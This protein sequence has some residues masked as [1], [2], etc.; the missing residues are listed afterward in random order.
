MTAITHSRLPASLYT[1]AHYLILPWVFG[2]LLWRG[3]RNHAYYHDWGQ[4][5]GFGEAL[6]EE[7]SVIWVHAVSVGEVQAALPILT[8]LRE[9]YPGTTLVVTTTTPTGKERLIQAMGNTVIHR[10]L[11]YDV[12][13]A[14]K[15]FLDGVRPVLAIVLETEIWPNLFAH[16][17]HRGVPL[18]LANA[19]LSDR[20][21]AGYRRFG[22]LS[23]DTLQAISLIAAQGERDAENYRSLGAVAEN[24]QVTGSVKFDIRLP[25]SLLEAAQVLRRAFG[26]ERGIW[27][28]ASTH[29]G[30]EAQIL[31][32]FAQVREHLPKA[33]L[34][35]VPRH[36]ERFDR[37][38]TLCQKAGWRVARRTEMPDSCEA[39]D[40]FLGDTMGELP[41]F[42]GASDLAFVGGSLMHVGGHNM[43]E[44]AA[45]GLPVL[46]G[47]W[48][49]NFA[50][51]SER[52]DAAG[53]LDRVA[54]APELAGRVINY[55][56]DA[57]LRHSTGEKGRQF[58][59][60]NRG[61]LDRLETI[62][63]KL[64]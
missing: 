18:L 51:I 1:A 33:L 12:P 36:P 60:Q 13:G 20:S 45:L 5:L 58:V 49:H 55:L 25:P 43:L 63:Q 17:R 62:V 24:I 22:R 37:V 41:L 2:H 19:R 27:I 53:A 35:L 38:S 64:L 3:L 59:E 47:P 48:V 57:N 39:V 46:V 4:R 16:C 28:A 9:R 7:T 14:V 32:A 11:P 23:R 34:V 26:V 8:R 61:A 10:Y 6:P 52:L 44:P 31:R 40:V 42:Y 30:E 56:A 21:A 50:D 29:E 15:R 54:D